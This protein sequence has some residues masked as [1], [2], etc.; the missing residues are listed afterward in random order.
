MEEEIELTELRGEFR[1]FD[2]GKMTLIHDESKNI[3]EVKV[4]L[5][6]D[7]GDY[8]GIIEKH[9]KLGDTVRILNLKMNDIGGVIESF[10]RHENTIRVTLVDRNKTFYLIDCLKY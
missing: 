9:Y 1:S 2:C 7:N 10:L 8:W 4:K 5:H 3:A 6:Y